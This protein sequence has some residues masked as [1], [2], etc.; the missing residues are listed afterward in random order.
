MYCN[1]SVLLETSP[2]HAGSTRSRFFKTSL[3]EFKIPQVIHQNKQKMTNS[4]IALT[5]EHETCDEIM[6]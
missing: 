4:R 5:L 1:S 3:K 6:V 2:L